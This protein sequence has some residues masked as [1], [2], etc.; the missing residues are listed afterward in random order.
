[1]NAH[2]PPVAARQSSQWSSSIPEKLLAAFSNYDL[3]SSEAYGQLGAL[4]QSVKLDG[5]SL[6]VDSI[7]IDGEK[8]SCPG[9]IFVIL[10]YDMG[11]DDPVELNDSY[12]MLVHFAV[13]DDKVSID[14][15]E[16]DTSSFYE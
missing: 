1:M 3:E 16:A 2:L 9:T 10:R 4:A 7:V 13:A 5:Y 6:D 8:W 15:V 12:P 14:G 11:S